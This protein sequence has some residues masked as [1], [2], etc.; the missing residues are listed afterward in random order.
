MKPAFRGPLVLATLALPALA[1]AARAEAPPEGFAPLFNGTDTGGWRGKVDGYEVV[2]GTLHCKPGH[3]GN[4]FTEGE[5]DDFVL[6]FEFKLAPGANNGLGIR[7]PP[8]GD[9]A[10]AAMEL[11]ILDDAHPKYASIAPWQA[12]GSI[13]GVVAAERGCLKPAGEWNVEEVTVQGSRVKVV[14]NGKTIVDA[15][16]A[17]FRDGKKPTAD[18]KPHPGLARTKGHIGFLGHG[19]EIWIRAMA[20]KPLAGPAGS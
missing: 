13:Y 16:V 20:I 3:G 15:D 5:Y 7:M 14:V 18:G 10:F 6:R 11:Q 1:T 8:T 19:D 9:A 17:E 12:H 4:V 2:D